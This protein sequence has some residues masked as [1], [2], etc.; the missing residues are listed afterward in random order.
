MEKILSIVIPA[1]N[2]EKYLKR[3]LFSISTITPAL[4]ERVE[5]LIINDGSSDAT[6]DIALKYCQ[7]YPGI[8]FLHSKENGGHG[9]AINTG[10]T[11]ATGKYFKVLDGDDWFSTKELQKFIKLLET[12]D[13]DAVASGYL[14]I[15]DGT[16]QILSRKPATYDKSQYGKTCYMSKG[17]IKNVI[18]MH[19]L[20]IKTEYLQ[21]MPYRIDENCFY[22]DAEYITY[23]SLNIES[24]YYTDIC[25]YM[26]RLGRNGQ[27]MDIK[28]MQKNR[29][30]HMKVYNSLTKFYKLSLK[31]GVSTYTK[32]Y[33][34]MCIAQIVENQFQIYISM[35]MENGIKEELKAWDCK[36]KKEYP[37]I[38]NSVGK[39]S[40]NILR[41][42]NYKLLK[43]ASLVYKL[44]RN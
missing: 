16:C 29:A 21:T 37:G 38:Y 17:E 19:S 11:L 23:P 1:Y 42:S 22:V 18:K 31:R 14:C 7:K 27:S 30:Q 26:Y 28:S 5:V 15:K 32:K 2:V 24:V 43:P 40:I 13:T 39:K 25:P 44:V 36:L 6:P 4:L 34:E 8:F 10:I 33:I 41:A 3:C 20:S 35:G 12:L 9:S